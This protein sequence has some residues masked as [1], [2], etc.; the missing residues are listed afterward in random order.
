MS[1]SLQTR[2]DHV[3][4]TLPKKERPPITEGEDQPF[5]NDAATQTIKERE[6]QHNQH[7]EDFKNTLGSIILIACAL[8]IVGFAIADAHFKI[9]SSL[10]SGAFDFA[11]VIATTTIGYFFG[12]KTS[13]K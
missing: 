5:V 11:K 2:P 1:T 10:F 3:S 9:E 7:V 6:Q 12:S 4:K 13:S 8:I